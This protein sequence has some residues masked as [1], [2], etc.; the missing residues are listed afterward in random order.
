MICGSNGDKRRYNL[1]LLEGFSYPS[2]DFLNGV[3]EDPESCIVVAVG[4]FSN[5]VS[6][7]LRAN[8]GSIPWDVTSSFPARAH[9][10]GQQVVPDPIDGFTLAIPHECKL[11]EVVAETDEP[12]SLA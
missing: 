8:S 9:G 4:S 11:G 7:V 3:R 5:H 1:Q 12:D 10:L 2:S 6:N